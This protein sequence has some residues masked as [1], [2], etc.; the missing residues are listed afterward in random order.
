MKV[1]PSVKAG[2]KKAGLEQF[3]IIG[4]GV[5]ISGERTKVIKFRMS[6]T[7]NLT[8]MISPSFVMDTVFQCAFRL[9]FILNFFHM[10][11]RYLTTATLRRRNSIFFRTL[12]MS[13]L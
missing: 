11:S 2:K 8:N 5:V 4:L 3:L 6:I 12:T 13:I 7:K 1:G 9:E 10:L